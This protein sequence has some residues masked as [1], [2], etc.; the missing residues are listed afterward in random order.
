ME[1]SVLEVKVPCVNTCQAPAEGTL[2]VAH[3]QGEARNLGSAHLANLSWGALSILCEV[4]YSP[5]RKG[6]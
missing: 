1:M 6:D 3:P 2:G 5:V 4:R